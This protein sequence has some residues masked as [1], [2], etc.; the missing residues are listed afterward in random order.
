MTIR[1]IS[2]DI[3]TD[4]NYEKLYEFLE[5]EK[6]E[7]LSKSFYKIDSNLD[8][9]EFC[10]KLKNLTNQ[11]DTVLVIYNSKKGIIHRYIRK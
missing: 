5:E 10:L 11:G 7:L 3:D 6:A 1:Y 8:F 9:E 2:Y 4:N